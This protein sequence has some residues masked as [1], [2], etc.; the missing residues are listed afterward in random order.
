MHEKLGNRLAGFT[1]CP[2]SMFKF[3]GC[4]H[5][6][7]TSFPGDD[8]RVS[9][10]ACNRVTS[11]IAHE[12]RVP[13]MELPE[14]I[15]RLVL[16]LTSLDF[17]SDDKPVGTYRVYR[18]GKKG[19]FSD[20]PT[21]HDSQRAVAAV[22]QGHADTLLEEAERM[23]IL[24][25]LST[26][27][28]ND[29]IK[30]TYLP[31]H[32]DRMNTDPVDTAQEQV[33]E[34]LEHRAVTPERAKAIRGLLRNGFTLVTADLDSMMK[35]VLLRNTTDTGAHDGVTAEFTWLD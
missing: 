30:L 1:S 2:A 23:T 6:P 19:L 12:L 32:V 9:C 5:E 21:E 31:K 8:Q 10:V 20:P 22:A 15:Q 26:K 24:F 3:L 35:R 18:V 13:I 29:R 11:E 7:Y 4:D 27:L 34:I 28:R 25:S 17:A 33:E 16:E 14:A